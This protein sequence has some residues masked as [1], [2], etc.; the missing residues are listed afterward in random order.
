MVHVICEECGGTAWSDG[1]YD[2]TDYDICAICARE[3]EKLA[4][5][6]DDDDDD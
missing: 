5:E 1:D 4:Q 2:T 6:W 3:R